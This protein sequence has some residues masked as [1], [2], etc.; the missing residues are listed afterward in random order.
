MAI[1]SSLNVI[2]APLTRKITPLPIACRKSNEDEGTFKPDKKWTR[3]ATPQ[4][5]ALIQCIC[6]AEEPELDTVY[7]ASPE[8]LLS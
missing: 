7:A 8:C 6:M 4:F 2:I 1:K 5:S 3:P